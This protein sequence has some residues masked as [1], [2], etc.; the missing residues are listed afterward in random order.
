MS[1]VRV[2]S[3]CARCRD[4]F[5]M[6][7]CANSSDLCPTCQRILGVHATEAHI[8]ERNSHYRNWRESTGRDLDTGFPLG[9]R[10]FA[11]LSTKGSAVFLP[12]IR[13]DEPSP[14]LAKMRA[15]IRT[16]RSSPLAEVKR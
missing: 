12:G 9:T 6:R 8:R 11:S 15:A 1:E 3:R 4:R 2:F 10:S 14:S 7:A 13:A 5:L 16:V